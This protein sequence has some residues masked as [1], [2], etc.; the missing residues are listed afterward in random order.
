MYSLRGGFGVGEEA[1]FDR[2]IDEFLPRHLPGIIECLHDAIREC[3]QR[4]RRDGLRHIGHMPI[5]K[6]DEFSN[7]GEGRLQLPYSSISLI[8]ELPD[9]PFK[10]VVCAFDLLVDQRCTLL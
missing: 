6:L 7:H 4:G 1:L 3:D 10:V 8:L 9:R 2:Q 5:F